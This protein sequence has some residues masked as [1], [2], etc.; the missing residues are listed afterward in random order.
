MQNIKRHTSEELKAIRNNAQ[1]SRKEG[2][3]ERAGK[4]NSNNINF[5][6]CNTSYMIG[7]QTAI[8][9]VGP[10]NVA[11]IIFKSRSYG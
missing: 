7:D 4:N 3:M 9:V 11:Q 5:Q 2:M 6:L 8:K 10:C 1:K